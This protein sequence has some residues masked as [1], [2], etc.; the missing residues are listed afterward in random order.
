M[1][2]S[3]NRTED[4]LVELG[5]VIEDGVDDCSV[6]LILRTLSQKNLQKLFVMSVLF[7]QSGATTT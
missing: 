5:P 6:D 4:F 2:I 3:T 7:V 1:K